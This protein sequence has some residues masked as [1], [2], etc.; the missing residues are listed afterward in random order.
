MSGT[1]TSTA[2]NGSI[3]DVAQ[4]Q[5]ALENLG[6]NVFMAAGAAPKASHEDLNSEDHRSNIKEM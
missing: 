6:T 5:S 4:L 2:F 1:S 3:S